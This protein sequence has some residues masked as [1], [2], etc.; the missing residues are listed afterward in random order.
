MTSQTALTAI[1]VNALPA[2]RLRR[3]RAAGVDDHGNP[4]PVRI[5]DDGGSP[6]RCCLRD[7][8]PGERIALLAWSPFDQR[9]PYAEVGPIFVHADECAGYD[10][11]GDWPRGFRERR[12]ILRAYGTDGTIK[13]ARIAE[14]DGAQEAVA[15]DLLADPD[16]AFVHSRNVLFGCY[17][18]RIDRAAAG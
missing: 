11:T 5:D 3:L 15:R 12:Q 18:F 13:D 16:V 1:T 6:L 7:A 10:D 14:P 9:G 8:R 2:D 17:M 4:I